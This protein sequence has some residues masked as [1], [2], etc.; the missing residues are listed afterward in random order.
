MAKPGARTHRAVGLELCCRSGHGHH[1]GLL[2][3]GDGNCS[4][5]RALTFLVSDRFAFGD[6]GGGQELEALNTLKAGRVE[7]VAHKAS[8]GI[9]YWHLDGI[10]TH[11]E[12]DMHIS[13][14]LLYGPLTLGRAIGRCPNTENPARGRGNYVVDVSLV[15]AFTSQ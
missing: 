9:G 2:N 1:T 6:Q 10:R 5:A 12:F 14:F 8:G 13:V 11:M 7:L 3:I 15:D 4:F